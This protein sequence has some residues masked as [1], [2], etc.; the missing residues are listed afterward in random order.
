MKN[1]LHYLLALLCS[2]L[3]LQS[4]SSLCKKVVIDYDKNGKISFSDEQKLEG[5]SKGQI[6]NLMNIWMAKAFVDSKSVISYSSK[7]DGVVVGKAILS[8]P[9]RSI[10]G[11]RINVG[12]VSYTIEVYCFDGK[13]KLL[14]SDFMHSGRLA[15]RDIGSIE[16]GKKRSYY[17]CIVSSIQQEA[18]TLKSSSRDFISK[19]TN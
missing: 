9:I 4:C 11:E 8:T 13:Y 6:H 2:L 1:K 12:V 15:V 17:N 3:A 7:E 14:I 10:M 19:R 5:L 16:N 18:E